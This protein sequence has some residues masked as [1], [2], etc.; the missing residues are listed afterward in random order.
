M[1]LFIGV[2][3]NGAPMPDE[4]MQAGWK[5][6]KAACA[7]HGCEP[8]R[9]HVNAGKGKAFCLTEA[10]SSDEVQAAHDE[11]KVPLV[12]VIEVKILE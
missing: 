9:A 1:A 5:A 12:D 11:A 4:E 3:D 10:S 8:I 7:N 2:H 6:Y